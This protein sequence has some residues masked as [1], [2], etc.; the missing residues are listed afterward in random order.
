M[1]IGISSLTGIATALVVASLSLPT[2]SSAVEGA[3]ATMGINLHSARDWAGSFFFADAMKS[4]RAWK[5][6]GGD[7]VLQVDEHGWPLED[8][9]IVVMHG[10]LES[11]GWYDIYFTGRADVAGTSDM[12]YDPATNTSH[13]RYE[14]TDPTGG[15]I[16]KLQFTNT[17][18]GVQNVKVMRPKVPGGSECYDTSVTFTDQIKTA[19]SKFQFVRYMD[20]LGA[21]T[22]L[23]DSSLQS[24]RDGRLDS[25]YYT[26][27]PWASD[28][29]ARWGYQ[30]P[31]IAYEYV[32]QFAN[33]TMTDPYIN[34][35][36]SSTDE[37]IRWIA[38]LFHERLQPDLKL[39]VEYS[40]EVWNGTF[41]QNG[42]NLR[43]ANSEPEESVLRWDGS[44]M[45]GWQLGYRRMA[46]RTVEIGN[47]FRDVFGEGQMMTRV[48][49][50]LMW[51]RANANNYGHIALAFL[52]EFYNTVHEHNAEAH[53]PSYYIY[54]GGG[55]GYYSCNANDPLSSVDDVLQ[56]GS[57]PP[58]APGWKDEQAYNAKLAACYGLKHIVYEG[59]LVTTVQGN[60]TESLKNA[61]RDDPR[62]TANIVGK[63]G[64]FHSV[65]G[66]MFGYFH[67][68]DDEERWG[69]S[70]TVMELTT[71]AWK[72]IDSLATID[73]A[74]TSEGVAAGPG[75]TASI[76]GKM[77][78]AH[79]TNYGRAGSINSSPEA[80]DIGVAEGEYY[81]FPFYVTENG[82]YEVSVHYTADGAAT[83]GYGFGG[84][85][86]AT[87]AVDAAPSVTATGPALRNL[88]TDC[89]NAAWV[90]S[91][92]GSFR[93]DHVEVSYAGP[94]AGDPRAAHH[95]PAARTC[96]SACQAGAGVAVICRTAEPGTYRVAL[97]DMAGRTVAKHAVELETSRTRRLRVSAAG[98][99]GGTYLVTFR[100][101]GGA[102]VGVS[103]L[104]FAR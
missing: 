23:I 63:I 65:G 7:G 67:S 100:S 51:Q 18:G 92:Q 60:L 72:A 80:G 31:G 9:E 76:D 98:L 62:I 21:N 4:A 26:Q 15:Q 61:V 56:S 74:P 87:E 59:G 84:E 41:P 86:L 77:W 13:C 43:A 50:V 70:P 24:T 90:R 44:D 8:A 53:P 10:L 68:N 20:L 22:D 55:A 58:D 39:Y 104:S 32:V 85:A 1:R 91:E 5:E 28:T 64:T 96:F 14:R 47:I 94:L 66:H 19:A 17:D 73:R 12:T 81:A 88:Y 35:Y 95:S 52:E 69:L 78:F 6:V 97:H 11:H 79:N 37:K 54:G 83:I 42:W 34:I 93:I 16:M 25:A 36:I 33:E 99:A 46:R 57:M 30:G 48:R 102:L 45:N 101:A 3:A 2:A 40:N 75:Q 29:G 38:E 49:P 27:C 89:M 103:H 71:P 82:A